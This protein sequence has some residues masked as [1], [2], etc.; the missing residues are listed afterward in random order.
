MSLCILFSLFPL[1]CLLFVTPSMFPF[2]ST[3]A[4]LVSPN[5]PLYIQPLLPVSLCL[6]FLSILCKVLRF[7]FVSLFPSFFPYSLPSLLVIFPLPTCS[8]LPFPFSS[9]LTSLPYPSLHLSYYFIDYPLSLF[10]FPLALPFLLTSFGQPV[11]PPF[12]LLPPHPSL[13]P[14]F[15][16]PAFL[17]SPS[18]GLL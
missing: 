6:I 8:F 16:P 3:L 2:L 11:T 7:T 18:P 17:P 9:S 13:P 1:F 15:P 10:P 5:S 4:F 14:P 12:S